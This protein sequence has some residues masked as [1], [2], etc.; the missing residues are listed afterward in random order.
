MTWPPQDPGGRSPEGEDRW[1]PSMTGP[2]DQPP[3]SAPPSPIPSYVPPPP[4]QAHGPQDGAPAY[5]APTPPPRPVPGSHVRYADWAERVGATLVDWGILLGTLVVVG[6][7]FDLPEAL[8]T[9]GGLAWFG[10]TGYFAW[11]NGSK[12]QSPGKALMGLRVVRSADGSTLG[13][14]VG[15]VRAVVLFLMFAFTGGLLYVLALL[16]PAGDRRK[17]A[18]HDKVVGASVLA[19]YPRARFG[20]GIFRP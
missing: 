14:P 6:A 1:Q 7:V 16:W 11:L 4:G 19:G 17:Q 2:T 15:L 5:A 9:L 10:L 13:G 8:E 18:L 3:W 12:G 20:P